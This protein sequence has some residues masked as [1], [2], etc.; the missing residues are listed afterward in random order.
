M[1][2][3]YRCFGFL[4]ICVLSFV[5]WVSKAEVVVRI[6]PNG[7]EASVILMERKPGTKPDN[8]TDLFFKLPFP[9]RATPKEREKSFEL[10]GR[11]F[12]VYCKVV[13]NF[14]EFGNCVFTVQKTPESVFSAEG[15]RVNYIAT[16]S[17]AQSLF[18]AFSPKK[19]RFEFVSFNKRLVLRATPQK[20]ELLATQK[21]WTGGM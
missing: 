4:G 19:E 1:K 5:A 21:N 12:L 13:T 17:L 2:R 11:S 9:E 3:V 6:E 15:R 10:P 16:G 20:F 14:I 7:Q 8:A 18:E